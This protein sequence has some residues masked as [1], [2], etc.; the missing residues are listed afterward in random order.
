MAGRSVWSDQEVQS[1]LP[2]FVPAADEVWRLKRKHDPE[3]DFFRRFCELGH[4]RGGDD[5][6][7]TRQGV[8]AVAPSGRFLT[9]TNSR[10]PAEVAAK[11]R[12]ALNQWSQMPDSDR[13]LE[14][15]PES[16]TESIERLESKY[17]ADGLVLKIHSRDLPRTDGATDWRATAWNQDYAWLRRPEA[18][19]LAKAGP[20]PEDLAV[21]FARINLL[22]N[23]R[24][25]TEAFEPEDVVEA[26][27]RCRETE[28]AGV[29]RHL[30]LRGCF[31]MERSGHWATGDKMEEQKRGISANLV[32][33][34]T[35]DTA[36]ERFTAFKA[37]ALGSRWGATRFNGR[38]DDPG[39][40]SIGWAFELAGTSPAERIA[41]AHLWDAYGW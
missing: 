34:A 20:I 36:S 11:M 40:S 8:Y 2:S 26:Q 10:E 38:H 33:L 1:L 35:Y 16:L 23:V 12:D 22:D 5:S 28:D 18:A 24:G 3:G 4:Y 41:P 39:P 25:Q 31:H 15:N 13:L 37:V 27:I 17:P 19:A 21:W 14:N 7:N 32:G 29:P 6:N 30:E 9:S